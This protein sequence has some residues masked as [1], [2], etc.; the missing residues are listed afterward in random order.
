MKD[1]NGIEIKRENCKH[2]TPCNGCGLVE[3]DCRVGSKSC[4]FTP[5]TKAYEARIS[6][7]QEGAEWVFNECKQLGITIPERK[8]GDL[9]GLATDI[10]IAFQAKDKRIQELQAREFTA[11]EVYGIKKALSRMPYPYNRISEEVELSIV[12]KCDAI[13][14]GEK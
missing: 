1:K 10:E 13:L 14:K 5:S 8:S 2:K 6:E 9:H 3:R 11:E 4:Q 12:A 7:L